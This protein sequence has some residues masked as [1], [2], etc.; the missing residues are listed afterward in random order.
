VV[1]F[2]ADKK[3][4]L[5]PQ[6]LEWLWGRPKLIQTA[7]GGIFTGVTGGYCGLGVKLITYIRLLLPLRMSGGIPPLPYVTSCHAEGQV[8]FQ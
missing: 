1:C 3:F 5:P 2:R 8:C 4:F 7:L 6:H